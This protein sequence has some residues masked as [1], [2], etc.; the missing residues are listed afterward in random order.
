M[1]TL[2]H[3]PQTRSSRIIWL[4]E[5][6]GTDVAI[7][8]CDIAYRNGQKIGGPD[9]RNPHPEGKV[10]A[11]IHDQT[12]ITES[13][14]V[15]LYLTDLFPDAGLG[16]PVGSRDRGAFLTWLSWTAGELEPSVFSR[17]TGEIERNAFARASYDA[18]MERLIK[19]LAAGP[20]LMGDRFTA[21]DIM[22][23][24]TLGWARLHLPD[25]PVFDAY[26]ERLS[27]RPAHRR[28]RD[29]DAPGS[30]AAAS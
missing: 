12:L 8:Y 26:L 15:A 14:A 28:A 27:T 6:L 18:A 13:A 21:A 2:F 16:A 1:L 25:N 4:I 3:A 9:P 19:A 17:M 7:E 24:S 10:P 20:W 11:L 30:L 23:G 29:R 22:I 5:E